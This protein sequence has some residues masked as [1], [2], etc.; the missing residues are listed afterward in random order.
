MTNTPNY[1][2]LVKLLPRLRNLVDACGEVR[3]TPEEAA[4]IQTFGFAA[5]AGRWK[6]SP[7]PPELVRD[8]PLLETLS[9]GW[10]LRQPSQITPSN[11]GSEQ[12]S[13][14][15]AL[16]KSATPQ[17]VVRPCSCRKQEP[18]T[19]RFCQESR[20]ADPRLVALVAS[21]IKSALQ[22]CEG[23]IS[24]RRLQQRFWRYGAA[25]FNDALRYLHG[26][27]MIY[28]EHI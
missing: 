1:A 21:K 20:R 14:R 2:A 4:K 13:T 8:N 23:Q 9:T 17:T 12:I 16:T 5:E 25:V 24:K 6:V 15:V 28:L 18:T 27:G 3:L 11:Q 19:A 7:L 26:C 22:R 10:G